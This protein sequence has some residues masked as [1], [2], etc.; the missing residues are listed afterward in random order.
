[1]KDNFHKSCTCVIAW[2]DTVPK[3]ETKKVHYKHGIFWG[4]PQVVYLHQK[5]QAR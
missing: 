1:M 3:M 4:K 2:N 5:C